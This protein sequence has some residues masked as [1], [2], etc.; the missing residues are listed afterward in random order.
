MSFISLNDWLRAISTNLVMRF[1]IRRF[2][3]THNTFT[4]ELSW[5]LTLTTLWAPKNVCIKTC[6]NSM[7]YC[8]R[9]WLHDH[10]WVLAISRSQATEWY[11][12]STLSLWEPTTI[13]P[14]NFHS[15]YLSWLLWL[16]VTL[17]KILLPDQCC[18]LIAS[19]LLTFHLHFYKERQIKHLYRP[20][21][22]ECGGS[23]QLRQWSLNFIL[24]IHQPA[25]KFGV[26]T[27]LVISNRH[28][29]GS[30]ILVTSWN[31]K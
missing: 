24:I 10:A 2:H 13:L 30:P 25:N 23:L 1:T 6:E 3:T 8:R 15:K 26:P 9:V 18:L 7:A 12:T 5:A 20:A 21:L 29:F 14:S 11:I 17:E 4:W 31:S 19:P 28:T 27:I 22:I 16:S